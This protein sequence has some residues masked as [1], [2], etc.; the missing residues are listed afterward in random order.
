MIVLY[1]LEALL[2]PQGFLQNLVQSHPLRG[3]I[4]ILGLAIKGSYAAAFVHHWVHQNVIKKLW[5]KDHKLNG[6][7]AVDVKPKYM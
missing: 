4:F 6:L 5:L 1:W 7:V 2:L 3:Y